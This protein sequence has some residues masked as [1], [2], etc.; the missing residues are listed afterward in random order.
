VTGGVLRRL[1]RE[2][3]VYGAGDVAIS[4]VSFLL[5]PIYTR[6]LTPTDYGVFALLLTIEAGA[7]IVMRWG[8]DGAF[9]RLYYDCPDREARQTLASSIWFFLAAVNTPLLLAGLVGAPWIAEA[10]FGTAAYA[11]TLRIFFL[12]TFVTGFFFIPF[13][14]YR[15]EGRSVRFAALTFLRAAGTTALRLAMV[16]GWKLGVFGLVVADL[17]L[18]AVVAV[19][20]APTIAGLLRPRVSRAVL[21]DALGFGLPRIPHGLAHQVTAL[22]DRWILNAF[23]SPDRVGI[24]SVG[25]TFGLSMKLLLSGFDY[26]W[27]PF[28]FDVMKRPSARDVYRRVTTYVTGL[29]VLLAV[30]LAA[31][32]DDLVRL[33]TAPPFHAAA[34]VVPWVALG[35]V[36]QGFYQLTAVGLSITKR[37][38]LLPVA[39][40]S[41]AAVA[42]IVNLILVPR[43][44]MMGA[45]WTTALS[46]ATLAGV[47]YVLSQ[48]VYPIRYD[49]RSLGWVVAAG[50]ISYALAVGLFDDS[51]SV[52][53]RLLLRG[54]VVTLAYLAI[55]A[56]AGVLRRD[57]VVNLFKAREHLR[58]PISGSPAIEVTDLAGEIATVSSHGD[59]V[60]P[61][62]E[63]RRVE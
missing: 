45:A 48:N 12:N 1:V 10:M 26:A 51:W 23:L 47:G 53:T 44:G 13:N 30:G 6:V 36:F 16:V 31:I 24:Y 58:S 5:I 29:L 28:V 38:R 41:A 3:A 11:S 7:K 39:T 54:V 2:V 8:V 22:S 52:T 17:V 4:A 60:T 49:W 19:A 40:A 50:L 25:A 59:V 42:V 14:L 37:T 21:Q 32:A 56:A 61:E 15:I 34:A 55:L 46:Y 27:T 62:R 18:T 33:M 57:E 63:R 43:F 20:L 35:V 9:I